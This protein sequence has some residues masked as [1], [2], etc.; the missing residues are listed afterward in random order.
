[1]VL[2]SGSA[3]MVWKASVRDSELLMYP[4]FECAIGMP[5]WVSRLLSC[6][7]LRTVA[8]GYRKGGVVTVNTEEFLTHLEYAER[9]LK[10]NMELLEWD[11]FASFPQVGRER[12]TRDG[13]RLGARRVGINCRHGHAILT[14]VYI[15]EDGRGQKCAFRDLRVC[16]SVVTDD[17]G[18]IKLHR[19]RASPRILEQISEIQE[20]LKK[21]GAEELQLVPNPEDSQIVGAVKIA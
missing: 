13:G 14:E 7:S 19:R 17:K 5:T 10:E 18:P 16:E 3:V 11:Y 12:F 2:R 8:E 9:L 1:M 4:T 6:D 20:R 15:R 21:E